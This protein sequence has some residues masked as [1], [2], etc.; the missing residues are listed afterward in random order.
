MKDKLLLVLFLL[1]GYGAVYAQED[2]P[3]QFGIKTGGNLYS[4]SINMKDLAAKKLKI[5]YQIGLSAEYAVSDGF[6]LQSGVFF[7][8]KGIRLKGKTGTSEDEA[9][10]SQSINLQYLQLP[11][12]ATYKIELVSDTKVFFNVGPYIAY[13]IGGKSTIKER[14]LNST[15]TNEKRNTDSFGDNRMK[16]I[17]Y[18]LKY[19]IGLEYEKFVFEWSYELGLVDI[20]S[21]NSE[22]NSI[23]NDKRFR[24][25]GLALSVG[26]KF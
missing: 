4:S 14:Y 19:S 24:N 17:D 18:G 12:L 5:G 3:F 10:W 16:K 6:Y 7:K 2:S 23:L 8:T 21:D 9:Y 22:I 15:R 25:Q 13:G 26:Y 11:I 1:W 20:G